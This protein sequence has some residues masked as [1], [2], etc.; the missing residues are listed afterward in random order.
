MVQGFVGFLEG[1]CRHLGSHG[2]CRCQ[3]EEL[4]AV[5]PRQVRDGAQHPLAPQDLVGE[6]GMS[7]MWM[8]AHTT[9]PPLRD[10]A[11]RRGNERTDRREDDRRVERLGRR[12]PSLAR[13]LGAELACEVLRR[14]VVAGG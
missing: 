2:N 8:P 9:V 12:G 14:V 10:G 4:L 3:R 5:A 1:E 13:P 7:L 6:R 11:Q